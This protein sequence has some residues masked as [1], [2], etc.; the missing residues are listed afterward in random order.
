MLLWTKIVSTYVL[1]PCSGICGCN[2]QW[3]KCHGFFLINDKNFLHTRFTFSLIQIIPINSNY[4]T[5]ITGPASQFVNICMTSLHLYF[6]HFLF[7]Q[8]ACVGHS[9][10]VIM[11]GPD[12]VG[13]WP[14]SLCVG[15]LP[16]PLLLHSNG[17]AWERTRQLFPVIIVWLPQNTDV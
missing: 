3:Q 17:N 16:R 7:I 13:K 4:N 10:A 2:W 8:S 11:T 12:T 9:A 14:V 6:L 5:K 15:L 1:I